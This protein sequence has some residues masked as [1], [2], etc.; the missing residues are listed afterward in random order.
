MAPVHAPGSGPLCFCGGHTMANPLRMAPLPNRK[1]E[2][3]AAEAFL[4]ALLRNG[5]VA[6][7]DV[8]Q[9]ARA[10]GLATKHVREAARALRLER[11]KH[12]WGKTGHW[13]RQLPPARQQHA[14]SGCHL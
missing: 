6:T 4:K 12:G 7:A 2:R 10:A 1:R 13:D 14:R 5:P 3:E 8:F 11:I 9:Q